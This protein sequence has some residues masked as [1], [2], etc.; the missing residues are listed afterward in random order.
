MSGVRQPVTAS[1]VFGASA[2]VAGL[3]LHTLAVAT[4]DFG[5]AWG[6]LSLRGNGAAIVLPLA[7][8]TFVLG[9]VL[10]VRRR[11][12]LGMALVPLGLFVGLFVALGGI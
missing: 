1:L 4:R 3:G 5:P 6:A 2:V 9:E 8:A 10:C 12:W 7:V 11:A